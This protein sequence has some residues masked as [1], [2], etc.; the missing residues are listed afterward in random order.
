M[1][2]Q[3]AASALGMWVFLATEIMFFGGM[4]LTYTVYRSIYP[5]VFAAA[6]HELN[7]KLGAIN[8]SVLICS[9]LTMA[10]GVYFSQKG[11]RAGLVVSLILTMLLGLVFLGVKASEYAEK[12]HHHL[13]PGYNFQFP[14]GEAGPA[15][16]YFSL[17]FGMTG[18]HALHMIIGLGILT[19]LLVEAIRGRYTAEYNTPIELSGLYWHFVDIIW[20]FLFPLLYLI[21][22]HR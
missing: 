9:S 4:F 13:V 15:Q 17:Y 21:D 8:T 7:V 5:A 12:F 14:A 16:L 2:Q 6:S 18:M 1:P 10:M 22:L 3:R 19:F 11:K 20:I